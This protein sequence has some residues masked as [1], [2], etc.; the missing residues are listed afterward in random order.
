MVVGCEDGGRSQLFAVLECGTCLDDSKTRGDVAPRGVFVGLR[1]RDRACFDEK[2]QRIVAAVL[3]LL[4]QIVWKRQAF[5]QSLL[6]V[7][8]EPRHRKITRTSPSVG[9][10]SAS[11]QTRTITIAA[12]ALA[13]ALRAILSISPVALYNFLSY[14]NH[15]AR[16][17]VSDHVRLSKAC[18]TLS[19][20][21]CPMHIDSEQTAD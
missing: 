16:F 11:F 6:A 21:R 10:G 17:W 15:R 9:V 19:S 13:P 18:R 1:K 2:E 5:A 14:Q 7:L 3:Q 8:F 4:S 12:E 20:G